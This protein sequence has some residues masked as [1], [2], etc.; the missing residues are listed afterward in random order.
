MTNSAIENRM[1]KIATASIFLIFSLSLS[2]QN[3][4]W[5]LNECVE[6]ALSNNISV[7]QSELELER[8]EADKL[9]AFGNFLPSLNANM[10]ASKNTSAT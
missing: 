3:K 4:Q 6:H 9:Q 1:K 10:S 5:T 2:A 7:K 8:T